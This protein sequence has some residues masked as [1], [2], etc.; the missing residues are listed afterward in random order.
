MLTQKK[1]QA[2]KIGQPKLYF[3]KNGEGNVRIQPSNK[4]Y[5]FI[6]N[7]RFVLPVGQVKVDQFIGL[8][9]DPTQWPNKW[10]DFENYNSAVANH[11]IGLFY[12]SFFI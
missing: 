7:N 1:R 4:D 8:T 3:W 9:F 11:T 2:L 12:S 6:K 10:A 5:S